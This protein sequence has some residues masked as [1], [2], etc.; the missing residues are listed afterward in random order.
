MAAR[1]AVKI[2]ATMRLFALL[3][4]LLLAAAALAG[5]GA[6]TPV[7]TWRVIGDRSGEAEALVRVSER[8]GQLEG[9]IIAVYP[10]PGV[11]PEALCERCPG[12][13][14]NQ[15]VQGMSILTGMRRDGDGYSGGEILD[16]D[17]GNLYRC[18]LTLSPD[19]SKLQ[20]RG[21]IGIPLLGRTQTWLRQ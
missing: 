18:T 5:E 12:E 19:N 16:P 14:R 9:R 15:P 21:Y 8:D 20:V 11:D 17:S 13:R 2:A 4:S 3:P 10:R 6:A 7:G 1:R